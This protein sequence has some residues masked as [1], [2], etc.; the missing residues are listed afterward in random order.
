METFLK[1][2]FTLVYGSKQLCIY[3]TL[4]LTKNYIYPTKPFWIRSS[5]QRMVKCNVILNP[6]PP[7]PPPLQ[8]P[9]YARGKKYCFKSVIFA[10]TSCTS[11]HTLS[12]SYFFRFNPRINWNVS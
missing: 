3:L 12:P 4:K 5:M 2:L 8:N 10:P 9:G 1:G 6:H 11:Q 7:T